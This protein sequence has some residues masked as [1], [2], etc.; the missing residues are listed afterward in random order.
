MDRASGYMYNVHTLLCRTFKSNGMRPK[1][2]RIS[3]SMASA[4]KKL[5]LRFSMISPLFSVIPTTLASMKSEC[6]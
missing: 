6:Y 3:E 5:K 4:L 2:E 1:R